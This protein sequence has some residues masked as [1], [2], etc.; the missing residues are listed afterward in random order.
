MHRSDSR[1][2]D[3]LSRPFWRLVVNSLVVWAMLGVY[4]WID[5]HQPVAPRLVEMP[6]WVPFCPVFFVPYLGLL[7]VTWWLPAVIRGPRLFRACLR[8]NVFGWLLVMPWWWF[9]PTILARPPLPGEPWTQSFGLLWFCDRPYNVF[10]CAHAIGPV[11]AA[12]FAGRDHPAWRWPLAGMVALG[13][14]SIALVWQ[15][16]PID[17]LP[18]VGAAF[19]GI[20]VGE[21]LRRREQAGLKDY[22]VAA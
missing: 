14:P 11:V 6:A 9:T 12:W 2:D 19:L 22:E 10:P 4:L 15:H 17:I 5:H 20:L 7:L 8:A 1:F 18:G 21:V 16:R 13:L 3:W